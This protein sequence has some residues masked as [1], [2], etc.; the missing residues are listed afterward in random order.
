MK[1]LT[2]FRLVVPVKK[3]TMLL[4]VGVTSLVLALSVAPTVF[5][6]TGTGSVRGTV[7][8]EQSKAVADVQVTMTNAETTYIQKVKRDVNSNYRFLRLLVRLHVWSSDSTQ[9]AKIFEE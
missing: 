6:Q 1:I 7:M 3:L 9:R 4:G 5:A 2:L 8:D